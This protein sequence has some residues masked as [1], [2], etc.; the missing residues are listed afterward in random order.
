MCVVLATDCT[1]QK[2]KKN[3]LAKTTAFNANVIEIGTR[4]DL[5]VW[6]GH[7]KYDKHKKPTKITPVTMFAL[8]DYGDEFDSYNLIRSFIKQQKV[9]K[10]NKTG[11]LIALFKDIMDHGEQ[12][13]DVLVFIDYRYFLVSTDDGSIY[14]F[15]YVQS[16]KVETNKRLI[17]TFSGHNKHASYLMQM[18]NFPHLFMS[19]SLDGT[20]RVWSLE[21]FSHLYTIEIPGALR[22]CTIFSKCQYILSQDHDQVQL[23]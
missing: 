3:F 5:G 18:Q 11:L 14:V 21:S 2:F 10:Q 8:K 20:A 19:V 1:D 16:G 22:Y 9:M 4:D 13:L 12:I 23:H 7:C 15:K 17:H 6:L